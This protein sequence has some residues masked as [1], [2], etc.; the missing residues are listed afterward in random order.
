MKI[1]T[2]EVRPDLKIW[3]VMLYLIVFAVY[4][5]VFGSHVE[6]EKQSKTNESLQ[7]EYNELKT[8][9]DILEIQYKRDLES[10]QTLLGDM[11]DRYELGQA[12]YVDGGLNCE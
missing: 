3:E 11:Q 1:L 2:S 8:N 9:Y 12:C 7:T 6:R 5:F 10:C 4:G